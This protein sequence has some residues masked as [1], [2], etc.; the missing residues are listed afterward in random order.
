MRERILTAYADA[1]I[2]SEAQSMVIGGFCYTEHGQHS[3]FELAELNLQFQLC[4]LRG[5]SRNHCN[6][7]E[8]PSSSG[9]RSKK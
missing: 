4:W 3:Q 9:R 5:S 1:A 6:A 8:M 7:S 2:G